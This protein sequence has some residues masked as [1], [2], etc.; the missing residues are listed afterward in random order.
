MK[1]IGVLGGLQNGIMGITTP[2]YEYASK[3]G[4]VVII[5]PLS[6]ELNTD[7][8][9]LILVGGADLDPMLYGA[10]PSLR[11]NKSNPVRNWFESNMLSK[12]IE[13]GT[14]LF[15]VCL[16]LQSIVAY[17]GGNLIQ[18][19]SI[20]H[21]FS[22]KYRDEEVH[23]L[24]LNESVL[25]SNELNR[26][27]FLKSYNRSIKKLKVNSLHHQAADP[28]NLGTDIVVHFNTAGWDK[29]PEI[30]SHTKLPII[31]VQFHPE[32]MDGTAAQNLAN[33]YIHKLLNI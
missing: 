3:F 13:S 14:P 21:P 6:E 27:P 12:Y 26:Y 29:T 15:G 5:N 11:T 32:E 7:I 23:G 33:L 17:F 19:N 28:D 30:I 4:D 24:K 9:L 25:Q 31:A 1:K 10:K 20:W 2:Y 22:S 8:D 18:H 16:G